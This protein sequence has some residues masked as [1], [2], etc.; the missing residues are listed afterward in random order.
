MDNK[1]V[2]ITG[3]RGFAGGHLAA[4]L[5]DSSRLVNIVGCDRA[6]QIDAPDCRALDLLDADAVCCMVDAI[7]P[8]Y[9]FHLAGVVYSRDWQELYRGNVETTINILEA[10]K[11]QQTP[12]RVVIAGSAAEYGVVSLDDLPILEDKRPNPVSPYGV[13]K[14]WQTAVTRYYAACGVDA[15]CGRIFNLIGHGAP[16]GLSVGAFAAQIKKIRRGE[17]L[18][19][20]SVGNLNAKRD[21]I[22]VSDACRALIAL[23]AAGRKGEAYNICSGA[24]VSM[25]EL[26]DMMIKASGVDV[27]VKIDPTRFK[28]ADVDDSFGSY[29]KIHKETGWSP[30]VSLKESVDSLVAGL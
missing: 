6:A 11:K 25:R 7:R 22:D 5:R 3:M 24:S 16:Q 18:P 13:S 14:V 29:E 2:F 19:V 17:A 20:I 1:T 10:A 21:F 30:S 28:P 9:I 15:V 27:E 4:V 26:L 23:A 12:V 8:D